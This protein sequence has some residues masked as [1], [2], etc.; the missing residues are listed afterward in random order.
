MKRKKGFTLIEMMIVILVIAVLALI[1]GLAVRNAGQRAK[2][3]RKLADVGAIN[4][5]SLVYSN[6][7]GTLATT[8]TQLMASTGPTGYQ[9]PYLS[10]PVEPKDPYTGQSYTLTN[11]TVSGPGDVI[12][13][14]S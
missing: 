8:V 5:A 6:D 7:T 9:G 12:N 4:D 10:R 1:V 2:T 14:T 3:S 13:G 11:G